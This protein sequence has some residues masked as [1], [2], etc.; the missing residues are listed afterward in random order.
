MVE[1]RMI[2]VPDGDGGFKQISATV[3]NGKTFDDPSGKIQEEAEKAAW[4]RIGAAAENFN[5]YV[6]VYGTD[7]ALEAEEIISAMYLEILNWREFYPKDLG[8]IE[9]FDQVCKLVNDW[10]QEHKN[11]V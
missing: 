10:F 6:K 5:K 9:R 1:E 2:D 3:H 7:H 11:S 4:E 8:G